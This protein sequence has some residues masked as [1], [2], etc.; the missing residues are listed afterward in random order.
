MFG[1]LHEQ[2]FWAGVLIKTSH[3]L[4]TFSSAVNI[5]I[6]YF[7]VIEIFIK[8]CGILWSQAIIT[9]SLQYKQYYWK[10]ILLSVLGFQIPCDSEKFLWTR[11]II[12][13]KTKRPGSW[14]N[15][16][17]LLSWDKREWEDYDFIREIFV[18]TSFQLITYVYYIYII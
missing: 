10:T 3:L 18:N 1:K 7:K 16:T 15:K 9:T 6:Y 11:Y 8:K 2:P 12:E 17:D 4:L 14:R 5:L 13:T